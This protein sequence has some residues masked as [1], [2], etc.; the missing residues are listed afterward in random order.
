M[1]ALLEILLTNAALATVLACI[2]GLIGLR[3]RQP[4]LLR[5]LWVLVLLRLLFPPIVELGV[6]LL[7]A[8]P[9]ISGVSLPTASPGNLPAPTTEVTTAQSISALDLV[10]WGWLLGATVV[11]GLAL[12]KTLQLRHLLSKATPAGSDVERVV[13]VL[14]ERL[15]VQPPPTL[16]V[17]K[18]MSPALWAF[19]GMRRLILPKNLLVHLSK[20]EL[21]TLVAHELSH[22]RRGDHWIRHLEIL[23][24][25]VHWW[26]PV[27]WWAVRRL[28]AAEEHCCDNAVTRLLP[29][30]RRAYADCLLKTIR[31]IADQ[32]TTGSQPLGGV[33]VSGLGEAANLK[34]RLTM[35]LTQQGNRPLSAFSRAVLIVSALAVL[36]AFPTLAQKGPEK[37]YEGDPLPWSL[38]NADV[39]TALREIAAVTGLNIIVQPGTNLQAPVTTPFDGMPWD[40]ALDELLAAH[41]LTYH[42]EGNVLWIPGNMDAAMVPFSGQPITLT[43]D[44]TPLSQ[45]LDDFARQTGIQFEADPSIDITRIQVT[46]ALKGVPWDQAVDAILRI[47]RL[48]YTVQGNVVRIYKP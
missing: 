22:L 7:Q 1:N 6:P 5:G 2:V 9:S 13:A 20:A 43:L 42:L 16:V 33:L 4:D 23:T 25:A 40:Q 15:G 31:H 37:V 19:L 44:N 46:V 18:A 27:A 21:E 28:R 24:L 29:E 36:G 26:N 41:N 8:P 12:R 17:D 14:A 39:G 30:G 38:E 48:S 45:V 10:T 35:I 32:G 3:W 34:G 47:N 11:L